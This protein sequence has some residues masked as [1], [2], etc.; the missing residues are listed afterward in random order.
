MGLED[1]ISALWTWRR[2]GPFNPCTEWELGP[3]PDNNFVLN[4]SW[5]LLGPNFLPQ[6]FTCAFCRGCCPVGIIKP[7]SSIL[8]EWLA[9]ECKAV[10]VRIQTGDEVLSHVEFRE[11]K[12]LV[13]KYEKTGT[14]DHQVDWCIICSEVENVLVCC[15]LFISWF[16]FLPSPIVTD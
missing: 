6:D 3:H 1:L 16:M 9:D 15:T 2:Y 10:G 4:R 8:L 12:S 13:H 11:L 5:T 14:G 7:Q